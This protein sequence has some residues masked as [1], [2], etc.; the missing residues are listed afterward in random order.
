MLRFSTNDPTRP[1]AMATA[2]KR[3]GGDTHKKH[4]KKHSVTKKRA[5]AAAASA[6]SAGARCCCCCCCFCWFSCSTSGATYHSHLVSYDTAAV[7]LLILIG[8]QV[9]TYYRYTSK[10]GITRHLLRLFCFTTAFG[11]N[12]SRNHENHNISKEKKHEFC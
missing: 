11:H 8:Y 4:S 1:P 7:Q 9:R 5:A 2:K 3:K 10:Y 12:P 6:A